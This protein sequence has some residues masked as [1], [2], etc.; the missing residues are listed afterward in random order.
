[1]AEIQ[2]ETPQQTRGTSL[3][4]ALNID[5]NQILQAPNVQ[6]TLAG[7]TQPPSDVLGIFTQ[8]EAAAG[9]PQLQEAY[10]EAQKN[11]LDAQNLANQ[12]Q[13]TLQGRR[14]KLG[15][16]R[17]EQA[18]AAAQAQVDLGTLQTGMTLA[19]SALQQ[20]QATAQQRANL[21]Y[22]EYRTKQNLLMEFPGLDINPLTDDM[23]SVSKAL[24]KYEKEQYKKQEKR[25]LKKML[26][27]LGLKTKGSRREL[28]KR[29][30]KHNKKAY[31]QL[32]RENDLKL[33]SLEM[34]VQQ[35][36]KKLN[37]QKL[38]VDEQLDA[39]WGTKKVQPEQPADYLSSFNWLNDVNK[40]QT[41]Y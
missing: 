16:M 18:Q 23:K 31:D 4:S 28:A 21:L 17:G 32:Q 2:A 9:V 3:L 33:Q 8:Q 7:G 6:Q 11:F 25:E 14:K 38:T 35:A 26:R 36:R 27:E 24:K 12:E 13:V 22:D 39:L 37:E 29:L 20:A 30:R 10:Q 15:V 41:T 40:L 5:P 34:Q 19:Q 1:M